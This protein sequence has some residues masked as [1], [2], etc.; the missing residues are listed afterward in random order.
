MDNHVTLP[1]SP[2]Y[3]LAEHISAMANDAYFVGHPEWEHLVEEALR[4]LQASEPAPASAVKHTPGP[5][6]VT[7]TEDAYIVYGKGL[8]VARV[9]ESCDMG[10]EEARA[11]AE[12]VAAAPELL[13]ACREIRGV[14]TNLLSRER[15]AMIS[16]TRDALD[17][18]VAAANRAEGRAS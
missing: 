12:L 2:G 5:W 14:A 16:S 9:G 7:T 11:N 18:A 17:R 10:D 3:Q 4:I 8:P 6:H 15:A 13:A 1:G